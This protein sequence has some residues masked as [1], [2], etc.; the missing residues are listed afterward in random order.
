MDDNELP[1][2]IEL[3]DKKEFI[4]MEEQLARAKK[5]KQ[6][7]EKA[8][9]ERKLRLEEEKK[10]L[11]EKMRNRANDAQRLNKKLTYDFEGTPIIINPLPST[12]LSRVHLQ[13]M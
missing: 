10:R 12:K 7:K 2:P 1:E 11:Q 8:E 3:D 9:H 13:P 5:E 6:L 4:S